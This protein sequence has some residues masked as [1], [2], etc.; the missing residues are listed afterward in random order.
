MA[1]SST[2]LHACL[3]KLAP[4]WF[5]FKGLVLGDATVAQRERRMFEFNRSDLP[6]LTQGQVFL[7]VQYNE[8]GSGVT[9]SS[10]SSTTSTT[11]PSGL[12]ASLTSSLST[13]FLEKKFTSIA[14]AATEKLGMKTAPKPME[15]VLV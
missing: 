11:T 12:A 9:E 2:A 14:A 15:K 7:L 8:P 5:W 13:A 4:C 3:E 1:S 6:F 10:S